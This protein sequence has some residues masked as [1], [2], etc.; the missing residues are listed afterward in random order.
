MYRMVD[1]QSAT[2]LVFDVNHSMF[3]FLFEQERKKDLSAKSY[4][5]VNLKFLL[6]QI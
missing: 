6:T 2:L 3:I 4:K 1:I 5:H